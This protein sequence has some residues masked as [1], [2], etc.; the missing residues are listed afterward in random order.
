AKELTGLTPVDF[1]LQNPRVRLTLRKKKGNMV[2]LIGN[3]TPTKDAVYAQLQGKKDVLVVPKSVYE[4]VDRT[5]DDL[6]DRTVIDF[7]PASATRIEIKEGANRVIELAKSA[8]TT[9]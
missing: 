2:L 4:R 7:L 3:E 8:A 6:R 1:G 9:N 5:L